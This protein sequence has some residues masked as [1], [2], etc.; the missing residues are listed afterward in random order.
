MNM[1]TLIIGNGEVGKA[2]HSVLKTRH[3]CHVCEHDI[4]NIGGIEVMHVCFPYTGRFVKYATKYYDQVMPKYVVINSTVKV[5]T[6]A[7]LRRKGVPAYYSPVRGI[8]P[9]L[10]KSLKT[11]VKYIAPPS[12]ELMSYFRDAGIPA[13]CYPRPEETEAL[14]LW[15][16]TQFA[17]SVMLEKEIFKWCME[18]KLSFEQVY[19]DANMTYNEGYA[20]LGKRRYIR[21]TLFH[22]EGKIGGH[23]IIPNCELLGTWA[24]KEVLKYNKTLKEA[25]P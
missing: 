17:W 14:K 11:F 23:C 22:M 4:P 16:T 7:T 19:T 21:P 18:H 5:G 3:D 1:K 12:Q 25:K 13:K 6:T 15:S 24:A 2:M 10:E 8:H 20:K 9:Y